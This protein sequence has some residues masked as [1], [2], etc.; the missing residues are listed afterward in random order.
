MSALRE[1]SQDFILSLHTYPTAF[2]QFIH[3]PTCFLCFSHFLAFFFVPLENQISS[4]LHSF[5]VPLHP[6]H[7]WLSIIKISIFQL[8]VIFTS[9]LNWNQAILFVPW[10]WHTFFQSTY[11]SLKCFFFVK[12]Y[13]V[14]VFLSCLHDSRGL[15]FLIQIEFSGPRTEPNI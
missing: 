12:V 10:P 9:H 7:D 8:N 15:F 6:S 14:V 11:L 2:P 13:W 3:M 5:P 1:L 4:S